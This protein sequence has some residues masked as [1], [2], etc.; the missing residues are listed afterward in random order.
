MYSVIIASSEQ[1]AARGGKGR[2][3]DARFWS[4]LVLHHLAVG[5]NVEQA[6]VAIFSSGAEGLE[7]REV[8]HGVDVSFSNGKALHALARSNVVELAGA[9]AT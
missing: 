6:R 4:F 1:I 2:G 5:A 8:A 3:G 7:V 9:V